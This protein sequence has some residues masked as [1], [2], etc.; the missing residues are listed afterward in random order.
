MRY[1]GLYLARHNAVVERIKT[2]ASNKFEIL[3]ENQV[4]GN[5]GLRPDLVIKR[6]QNIFI[7]DV[8]I[9][10]DNRLAAFDSAARERVERYHNLC[11]E[12]ATTDGVEAT[13]V[14]FVVGALGGWFTK[15]DEFLHQL[16]SPKYATMM[17]KLC[18]SEVIGFSRDFYIQHL[19]NIPQRTP[20]IRPTAT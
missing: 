19:T 11:S 4:C 7:I 2:T 3:Y 16:C 8:T 10:F 13:V 14:P 6:S 9:P 1:S 12:L 20:T 18:I 15:N 17:R 5:S